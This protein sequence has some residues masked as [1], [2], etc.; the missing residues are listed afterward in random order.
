MDLK[1]VHDWLDFVTSKEKTG[2]FSYQEK[3]RALDRA[4]MFYFDLFRSRYAL[5]QQDQDS[6]SPFKITY[7]LTYAKTPGGLITFPQNYQSLLGMYAQNMIDNKIKVSPIEI[8]NDDELADRLNNQLRP[9]TITDP[10]GQWYGRGQIQLWP[11]VPNSGVA[12]YLRRP[13]APN[14][15]YT[16]N[17]RTVIYDDINSTQLEWD[18]P[19]TNKIMMKAL[20]YLGINLD[21]EKMIAYAK[22]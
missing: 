15:V 11:Q 3:D 1:D 20:E 10:I 7:Q 4:Q 2:Y 21:N 17:G 5:N 13:E 16:L 12:Y 8:I 18:E 14:F 19:C 9:V 22:S 6:L